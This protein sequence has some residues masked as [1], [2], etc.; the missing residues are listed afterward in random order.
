MSALH[1]HN[2]S[3]RHRPPRR[4]PLTHNHQ[5]DTADTAEPR[6]PPAADPRKAHARQH[7]TKPYKANRARPTPP[8]KPPLS[9]KPPP[10]QDTTTQR[11]GSH[12]ANT[13]HPGTPPAPR[14][15][16]PCYR[17][18]ST[19]QHRLHRGDPANTRPRD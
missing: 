8:H 5:R 2:D 13:A 15:R 10:P 3:V 17:V 14:Q 4:G 12:T 11:H 16:P 1:Q 9:T 6:A 19:H 7:T 18:R